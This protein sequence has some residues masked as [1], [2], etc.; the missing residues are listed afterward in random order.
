MHADLVFSVWDPDPAWK[1]SPTGARDLD[2]GRVTTF[3]LHCLV[4]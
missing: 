1:S 3:D 4:V 2:L